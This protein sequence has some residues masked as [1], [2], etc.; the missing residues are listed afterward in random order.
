MVNMTGISK[1]L[2]S[3]LT[4]EVSSHLAISIRI[5]RQCNGKLD[6]DRLKAYTIISLMHRHTPDKS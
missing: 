6:E 1:K 5:S 4:S 2:F 3:G